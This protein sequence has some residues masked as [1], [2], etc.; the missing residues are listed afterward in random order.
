MKRNNIYY[1]KDPLH[2]GSEIRKC[3]DLCQ[4]N[5]RGILLHKVDNNRIALLTPK[6]SFMSVI[7]KTNYQ[8]VQINIPDHGTSK[9]SP[10]NK[11]FDKDYIIIMLATN[12][13]N[14]TTPEECK[15]TSQAQ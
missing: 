5:K 7:A 4:Y 14:T 12:K 13:K 2:V 9:L 8:F 15:W 6:T 10:K 11:K 1:D 3:H